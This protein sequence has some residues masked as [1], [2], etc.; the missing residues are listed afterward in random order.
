MRFSALRKI[1][2][3]F[4]SC[5][6]LFS[7]VGKASVFANTTCN[8]YT[9][10][11]NLSATDLAQYHI[12]GWLCVPAGA[13]TVQLT[14]SGATYGHVYW[15]FPYQQNH[16]SYTQ[17]MNQQGY[18]TFNIDR[19]GIGQSDHPIPELVTIQT[20]SFVAHQLIQDLRTGTIGTKAFQK[21]ILVGHSLGSGIAVDE[22]V[23]YAD[24]DRIVL[25]GD[26][27]NLNPS[28]APL[29]PTTFY[30][31]FLDP[32]FAGENL[33]PGYLTTKPGGIRQQLFYYTPNADPTVIATD[34]ATK[35]TLTDGEFAGIPPAF[36]GPESLG[37]H[38]PVLEVIGQ[39]DFL[40]CG[41]TVNCN[42][43]TSVANN[44]KTFYSPDAHLQIYIAS[45][46]GH[47]VNLHTNA[48]STYAAIN[49]WLH[50]TF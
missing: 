12:V 39:F 29:I 48:R 11:V 46:S 13:T 47:D 3:P 49:Q 18:A 35:E 27:H 44:E 20:N 34:E 40:V 50:I 26:I 19:I 10:P 30:P 6:L 42:D 5:L 9:V 25:T 38:V 37:I 4:L 32:R 2:L 21:V 22:A 14:L 33:L 41:G 28:A 43:G 24:V 1:I 17:F 23:T 36:L 15:D 16:Y 45:D 7:F 8:Q 31:A